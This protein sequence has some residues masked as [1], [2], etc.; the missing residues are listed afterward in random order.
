MRI[1]L[2]RRCH[3]FTLMELTV[4]LV[5]VAL[6]LGG[7][8]MPLSAQRDS[9]S[10]NDTV[11]ALNEIR[12]ALLGFAVINGRLPCP[13][14]RT[15]PTHPAYGSEAAPGAADSAVA[16]NCT[17]DVATEGF[18]PWKTLG[19]SEYDAW[20]AP[21]TAA[22]V[23]HQGR[24]RYRVERKY[25][26]ATTL[27]Q[28]ILL[29]GV[30]TCPPSPF[31]DDCITIQNSAGQLLNELKERPIAIV[32]S[33]GPDNQPDGQN[34]SYEAN[35]DASPTYQAGEPTTGFNDILIWIPRSILANRLIAVGKLP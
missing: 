31:P 25:A 13:D 15:D 14:T 4:V 29:P 28:V 21:W 8:L 26:D 3:G 27:K 33:V 12:N 5:I 7:L 18:L 34:A 6:L 23:P 17:A 2:I 24:W 22:T 30:S 35:K 10:I 20:G 11:A 9:K 19:V 16:P 32:Y 1:A